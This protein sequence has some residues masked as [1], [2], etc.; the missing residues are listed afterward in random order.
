M[1]D[2]GGG[3][4]AA[5]GAIRA[6]MEIRYPGEYTFELVDVYRRY[7]PP[8]FS[9]LPEIYPRWVN[10]AAPTWGATYWFGDSLRRGRLAM[11]A[12]N[13]LWREG[14]HRLVREHPAD[15]VVSLHALF[16]R[17]A[18]RAYHNATSYRP[19]FLTVLTDLASTHA[20][21]YEKDVDRC[22]VPNEIAYQKGR[23]FGLTPDQ[24]RITG[25]PIHP[26][27]V[28]EL[29]CK[30]DARRRL[31]W[32]ESL[33]AVLVVGGGDG[34]GPVYAIARAIN[35]RNLPIQL[36]VIAGRNRNLARRLQAADW[37][38]P[39]MI[40]PFVNN[41][42]DLMAAADI[43]VTKAG[44]ATISEACI[45]G[46]PMV[47]SGAVPGQEAGNVRYIVEREA[48]VYAPGPENTAE[49]VAHWLIENPE[50]L[51][52]HAER[53]RALARPDAIWEIADEIHTHADQA[54]VRTRLH[55][56]C[57]WQDRRNLSTAPEEGWVM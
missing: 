43:L 7:T 46:L 4:R 11:A 25:L 6:A 13:W 20:F 41:I 42:P 15:V 49:A 33:P 22:L 39:T 5:A 34:M 51:T 23:Q 9:L 37:N 55:A 45:A 32:D 53:A 10:W 38:Q 29:P 12:L 8:P 50:S 40:Y 56:R 26:R 31:G 17:P 21:W 36:A 16:S 24:L 19:P 27:F 14:M 1:S 18:M 2:T 47:I 48:G 28:T 57:P 44:P 35:R 52:R 30:A 54:P 3:H